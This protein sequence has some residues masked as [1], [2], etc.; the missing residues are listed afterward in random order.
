M[1]F[2]E[3]KASALPNIM[4]FTT[5]R[6]IYIPRAEYST[7][8]YACITI[9]SIVTNEA[10]ITIKLGILIISGIT[11]FIDDISKFKSLC[12]ETICFYSKDDP[13]IPLESLQKFADDL[14]AK[15]CIY[16]YSGHF[17]ANAGYFKFE[18]LLKF[19]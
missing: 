3:A 8:R 5:I 1:V 4:Q 7:G 15:H 17:N 18:D 6:G 19:L 14:G 11:F 9:S 10:I 16:E 13:Y 12:E 2:L